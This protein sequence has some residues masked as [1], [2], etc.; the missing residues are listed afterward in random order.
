M[1]FG[2]LAGAAKPSPTI[3]LIGRSTA[4]EAS[5]RLDAVDQSLLDAVL[6]DW[7]GADPSDCAAALEGLIW[8]AASDGLDDQDVEALIAAGC[9]F[10]VLDPTTAP[11]SIVSNVN[12]AKIVA[13]SQ[14]VDRETAAA[15]RALGMDGTL[16]TS[17]VGS[18]DI[19]FGDLVDLHRVSAAAGGLMLVEV[20]EGLSAAKLT[21]LRDA[22]VDGVVS[23][24]ADAE[25]IAEL[26]G[27]IREMTP[28]QRPEAGNL[29]SLQAA[30]PRSD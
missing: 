12:G 22:G 4:A 23:P 1:G 19:R 9:D 10:F 26:G 14:P 7:N 3:A 24:L 5:S 20:S 25:T 28:R 21:T 30:A 13:L 6:L 8:G 2:A 17:G 29:R 16:N 15:L 27:N 18:G 11:G